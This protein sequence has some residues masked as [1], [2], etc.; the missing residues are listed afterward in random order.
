MEE[1][2]SY[3]FSEKEF[4][5]ITKLANDIHNTAVILKGFCENDKYS[6]D[7]QNILSVIRFLHQNSDNLNSIFITYEK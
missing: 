3:N 6:E 7:L 5:Q 1:L 4:K 2:K